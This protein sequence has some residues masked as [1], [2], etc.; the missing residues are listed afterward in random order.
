MP[1]EK[2]LKTKTIQVR[3]TPKNY[4]LYDE[5][6]KSKQITKTELFEIFLKLLEDKKI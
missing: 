4:K 2:R 1:K 3:V 5:Y 6:A